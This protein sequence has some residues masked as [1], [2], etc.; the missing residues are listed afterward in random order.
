MAGD[1]DGSAASDLNRSRPYAVFAWLFTAA[2]IAAL[3]WAWM[4]YNRWPVWARILA[5]A[6][7]VLT[8]PAGSDLF[9]LFR[10]A[11]SRRE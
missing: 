7:L 5:G 2:W 6:M 4:S 3:I 8:T 11:R 9:L 10:L 1:E